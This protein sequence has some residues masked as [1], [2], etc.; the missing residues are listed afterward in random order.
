MKQVK[1]HKNFAAKISYRVI[2]HIVFQTR[3]KDNIFVKQR[4]TLK[5]IYCGLIHSMPINSFII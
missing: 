4:K 5:D 2:S 3:V 1:N